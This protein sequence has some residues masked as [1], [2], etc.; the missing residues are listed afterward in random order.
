MKKHLIS[1]GT[2]LSKDTCK[3]INGGNNRFVC[4]AGYINDTDTCRR[5]YYPHP[6]YG[7]VVCCR[8]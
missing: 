8:S 7:A 2:E 1:L 3:A 4:R 5:G 6:V